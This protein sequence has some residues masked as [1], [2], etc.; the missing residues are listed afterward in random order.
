MMYAEPAPLFR[1]CGQIAEDGNLLDRL[2]IRKADTQAAYVSYLLTQNR[3]DLI[4]PST[5]KLMAQGR[6]GRQPENC[7]PL[8]RFIPVRENTAYELTGTYRTSGIEPDS[9]L[10]WRVTDA[11]TG[12]IFSDAKSLSG[13]NGT[14][15]RIR[16]VASPGCR[17]AR[18]ALAYRRALGTTRIEGSITLGEVKLTSNPPQP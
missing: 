17:L 10:M 15:S 5:R 18:I 8:I 12:E 6:S 2:D 7:E 4:E 13:E 16:F 11:Y 1:L 9:G 14:Q 3:V